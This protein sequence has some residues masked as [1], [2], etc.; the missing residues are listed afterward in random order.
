MTIAAVAISISSLARLAMNI[1][2]DKCTGLQSFDRQILQ[3][4]R[5]NRLIYRSCDTI[6]KS[7]DMQGE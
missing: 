2:H 3:Y 1:S 4:F 5:R 7:S 6:F